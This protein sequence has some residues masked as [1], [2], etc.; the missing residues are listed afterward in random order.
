MFKFNTNKDYKNF[1]KK[2]KPNHGDLLFTHGDSKFNELSVFFMNNK[3]SHSGMI[4]RLADEFYI[5][6]ATRDNDR[7]VDFVDIGK[8]THKS[9][10]NKT[11]VRLIKLEDLVMNTK[12]SVG[13]RKLNNEMSYDLRQT[14]FKFYI[15]NRHKKFETNKTEFFFSY[16]D[17]P[18]GKNKENFNEVF[19]S[20]LIAGCLKHIKWLPKEEPSNEYTPSDLEKIVILVN[21]Y[22]YS[23]DTDIIK[24]KNGGGGGVAEKG[25]LNVNTYLLGQENK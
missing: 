11:G 23:N 25:S 12:C 8:K 21:D 2:Y 13:I 15:D 5:F 7:Y 24:N 14:T 19:C 16:Y 3:W 18:F 22:K 20:E 6:E 4:F 1:I 17:G 9:N 10:D